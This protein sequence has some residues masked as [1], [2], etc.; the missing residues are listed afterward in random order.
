ML[1]SH[2]RSLA[3]F[4]AAL[5]LAVASVLVTTPQPAMAAASE[6]RTQVVSYGDLDL[7]R[8]EGL[9]RLER[10]VT[11]A[12]ET[13]CAPAPSRQISARRNYRACVAG[14]RVDADPKVRRAELAAR[15]SRGT[16]TASNR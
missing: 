14:A 10:R 5:M 11:D 1:K 2:P 3:M 13:V 7:T 4:G 6:Q 12:I 9:R 16:A 8:A 15:A